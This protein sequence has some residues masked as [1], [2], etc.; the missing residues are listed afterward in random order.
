MKNVLIYHK[1]QNALIGGDCYLPLAFAAELQKSF[2]VTLVTNEGFDV[3]A[4][5]R[6]FGVDVD[7]SR[8]DIVRISSGGFLQR[9]FKSLE[10]I[11]TARK[12]KT[13]SRAAD[14]CISTLNII[15]FLLERKDIVQ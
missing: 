2:H 11:F 9:T 8:L 10:P 5:S 15:D 3:A 13:L 7:V 1:R 12:L 14:I 6:T 4:A